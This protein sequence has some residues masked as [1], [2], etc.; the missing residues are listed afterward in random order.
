MAIGPGGMLTFG[1][2]AGI[3][4]TLLCQQYK[5]LIRLAAFAGGQLAFGNFFKSI[6]QVYGT[7]LPAFFGGKRYGAIKRPIYFKHTHAIAVTLQLPFINVGKFMP[8]Y[9][10]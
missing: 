3:N 4:D 5:W 8:C 2:T 9:L 10:Q 7:C 1:R 6:A